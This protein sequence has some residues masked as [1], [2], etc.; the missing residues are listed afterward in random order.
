M[1]PIEL[2]DS[3]HTFIDALYYSLLNAKNIYMV[4]WMYKQLQ[5]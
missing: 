1:T 2:I 5:N 4:T 3:T